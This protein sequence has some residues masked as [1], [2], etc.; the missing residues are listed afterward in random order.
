M[1]ANGFLKANLPAWSK[2]DR[3]TLNR[4]SFS[5]FGVLNRL[6]EE[7]CHA[8]EIVQIIAEWSTCMATRRCCSRE[9]SGD[10]GSGSTCEAALSATGKSPGRKPRAS[11]AFS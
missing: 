10:I 9:R 2:L 4:Y 3:H 1:C 11:Y 7:Q 8:T 5:L 6:S